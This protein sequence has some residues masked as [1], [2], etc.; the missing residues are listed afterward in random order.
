MLLSQ[1]SNGEVK[2]RQMFNGSGTRDHHTCEETPSPTAHPE[3]IM[4]TSVVDAHEERDETTTNV[5]NAFIQAFVA[6]IKDGED[7]IIMKITGVLVDMLVDIAP[8]LYGPYVVFERGKKV[9]MS[10]S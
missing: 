2:G 5:P 8:E 4:L 6:D 9:L 1:K 7:R 10:K 3:S